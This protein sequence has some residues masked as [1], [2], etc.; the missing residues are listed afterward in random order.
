[1][2]L[3]TCLQHPHIQLLA[4]VK[5]FTMVETIS[6]FVNL[7]NV[8]KHV[9]GERKHVDSLSLELCIKYHFSSNL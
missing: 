7:K 1:M 5:T 4:K 6:F 3:A 9:V 2:K 8:S